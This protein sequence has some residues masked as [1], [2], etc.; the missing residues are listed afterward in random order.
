MVD[1][2]KEA[3][4]T[5]KPSPSEAIAADHQ[6]HGGGSPARARTIAPP[7]T[8][9]HASEETKATSDWEANTTVATTW[10]TSTSCSAAKTK[11]TAQEA[12]AIAISTRV[13]DIGSE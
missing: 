5:P 3:M 10:T 7:A 12:T 6:A 2:A 4:D 11:P 1:V 13:T 8:A 9:T